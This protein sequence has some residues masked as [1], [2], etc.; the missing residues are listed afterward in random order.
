V[1]VHQRR[2]IPEQEGNRHIKSQPQDE[3]KLESSALHRF[4][5]GRAVFRY[6]RLKLPAVEQRCEP[7]GSQHAQ[8]KKEPQD[9][10]GSGP[11]PDG[12][13]RCDEDRCSGQFGL[14]VISLTLHGDLLGRNHQAQGHRRNQHQP[15]HAA[16]DRNQRHECN[17]R[18]EHH[19]QREKYHRLCREGL[20]ALL[21]PRDAGAGWYQIEL[22]WFNAGM[23]S[24]ST[25]A[26]I[27]TRAVMARGRHD[28][29][30]KTRSK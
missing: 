14:T 17:G 1:P 10:Q 19:E 5:V 4:D 20:D 29:S 23:E 16:D 6:Q 3:R 26:G 24:C 15:H 30:R 8:R 13:K 2:C 18:H 28:R 7:H 25:S 12:G 22:H 11:F 27:G 21:H 9:H